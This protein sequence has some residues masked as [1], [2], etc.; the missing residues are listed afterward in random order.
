M[1]P[2]VDLWPIP[3]FRSHPQIDADLARK[4]ERDV[5]YR[6]RTFVVAALART[7]ISD[8]HDGVAW[9]TRGV[10]DEEKDD[11]RWVVCVD[12][13]DAG[14]VTWHIH[15]SELPLFDVLVRVTVQPDGINAAF[16][17]GRDGAVTIGSAKGYVY[18]GHS[19]AEKYRRIWE[20]VTGE[21]D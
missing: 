21:R 4:R 15:D 14:V 19:T 17:W 3:P 18:D 7:M 2:F 8:S 11:C 10:A 1:S 16:Q 6:E 9:L 12:L 5:A 13:G 20:Y